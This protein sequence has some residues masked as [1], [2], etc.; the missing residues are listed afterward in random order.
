MKLSFSLSVL[1][2]LFTTI[3][4]Y[5]TTLSHTHIFTLSSHARQLIHGL[6]VGG[7]ERDGEEEHPAEQSQQHGRCVRQRGQHVEGTDNNKSIFMH[8]IGAKKKHTHSNTLYM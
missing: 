1:F 4:P 5:F 7:A 2:P 8:K 6:R 3:L